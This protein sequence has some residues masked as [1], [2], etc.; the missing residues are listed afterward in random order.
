MRRLELEPATCGDP[1][2]EA[3]HGLTGISMPDDIVMRVAAGV[4][5]DAALARADRFA[6][7]LSEATARAAAR[8]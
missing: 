7:A 4:E 2:C 3:E 8:A 1:S 6:R 5:G